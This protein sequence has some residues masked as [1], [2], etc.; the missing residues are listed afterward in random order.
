MTYPVLA[1]PATAAGS[2]NP[3]L[4]LTAV[5]R[6]YAAGAAPA[7]SQVSLDLQTG[8]LLS[9]LGPSGC[10]KTTLLRLIAGFE[11]PQSGT[12]EIAQQ[13]VAGAGY[14]VP[15][16]QRG[17]G[18]VFQDYA[19]F[20]HLTVAQNIGFGLAKSPIQQQRVQETMALV[21]LQG[22]NDRFPHQLSGG[23]QQRVALARALA[24]SP[25]LVLLDEPLSNLDVQVRLRLRQELRQILKAAGTSAVLVTHDQEEALSISDRVAVMQQGQIEQIGSPETL[26]R[27]PASR[28]VA[29]FVTQT[30][31]LLAQ[32]QSDQAWQTSLGSLPAER[33]LPSPALSS[34]D[35]PQVEL[36]L[37]QEDL[38]LYPDAAGQAVIQDRQFLG[39]EYR[40]QIRLA[41]GATLVARTSLE[42]CFTVGTV[43]RPAIAATAGLRAF[44]AQVDRAQP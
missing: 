16:E 40:Y 39:R 30:N 26:Y 6:Q 43:V 11:A 42:N 4:R 27:E 33:L 10:G 32:R 13:P 7:V 5:T 14:W 41:D 19:L 36:M 24:P 31:F 20:P 37:R 34:L 23:Q 2:S 35:Q 28:F 17:V 12:V 21:G 38:E 8:D 44:P 1:S 18:M 29:E 22:L 3:I 9:L 15:P 25:V